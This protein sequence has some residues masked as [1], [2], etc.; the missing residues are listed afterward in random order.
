[1]IQSL[2][3]DVWKYFMFGFRIH[4][5]DVFKKVYEFINRTK[6]KHISHCYVALF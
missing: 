5:K 1:M 3:I 6:I 2:G 4:E